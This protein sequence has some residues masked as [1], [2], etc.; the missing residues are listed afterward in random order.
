MNEIISNKDQIIKSLE[1][2]TNN[3]KHEKEGPNHSKCR[4]WNRGFCREGRK[5]RYVHPNED[6]KRYIETGNCEDRKCEGRHRRYCRYFNK[7]NGCYRGDSCQYLHSNGRKVEKDDLNKRTKDN[8]ELPEVFKCKHC[9]FKTPQK[10][11][12]QKHMNTKHVESSYSE[13]ISSFIYRLNLDK[14]KHEYRDYFEWHG[15]NRKEACYVEKMINRYGSDFIMK[16]MDFQEDWS[17]DGLC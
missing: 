14:F 10:V 1:D 2:N 12:L 15:F 9:D 8:K 6:C 4:Y 16:N 11:T 3:D 5:C 13:S 17:S 7:D